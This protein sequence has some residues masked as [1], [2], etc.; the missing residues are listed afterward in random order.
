MTLTVITPPAEPAV[1]LGAA[2]AYLRIGHSGEDDLVADLIAAATARL[3]AASGLSL[4]TR[5]LS[6][7][8]CVW[9][10]TLV[11]KGFILRP[12][13]ASTL[14]RVDLADADGAIEDV[15]SRFQLV[16]G[17]LVVRPWCVAPAISVGGSAT[18]VFNTGYGSE[19]QIPE[20]LQLAVL[21]LTGEAYRSGRSALDGSAGLPKD[22]AEAVMAYREL[23]V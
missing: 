8:F 13:P 18:V 19:S 23:R 2:K 10:A 6:R 15:T 4:V 17:R 9:P 21:R 5:T 7:R 14:V 12:K 16:G 22:V 20:D 3:E 11:G 1:T